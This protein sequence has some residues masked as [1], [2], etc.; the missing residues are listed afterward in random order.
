MGMV[1]AA[2]DPASSFALCPRDFPEA[3]GSSGLL[4]WEE[5]AAAGRG[6][7]VNGGSEGTAIGRLKSCFTLFPCETLPLSVFLPL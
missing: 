5:G 6:G 3:C 4:L 1:G 7:R 2:S